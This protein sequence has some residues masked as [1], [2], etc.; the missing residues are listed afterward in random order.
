LASAIGAG[1]IRK[2]KREGITA[3]RV[4]QSVRLDSDQIANAARD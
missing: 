4:P 3:R 2:G 1:A